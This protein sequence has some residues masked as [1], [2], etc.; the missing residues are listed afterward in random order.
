MQT[1]S[2]D[3]TWVGEGT[4]VVCSLHRDFVFSLDKTEVVFPDFGGLVSWGCPMERAR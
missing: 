1:S 3:L 2:H 4:L